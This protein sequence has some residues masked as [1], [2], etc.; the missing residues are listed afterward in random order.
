[1][2]TNDLVKQYVPIIFPFLLLFPLLA[3]IDMVLQLDTYLP[4]CRL[5]PNEGV[6]EQL[7][8]IRAFVVVLN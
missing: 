1:M 3:T 5:V 7:L 8:G 6:F 4:F 2:Y